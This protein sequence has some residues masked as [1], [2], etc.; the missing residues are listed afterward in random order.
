M[1]GQ[2]SNW[3]KLEKSISENDFYAIA[4]LKVETTMSPKSLIKAYW[5][6][7]MLLKHESLKDSLSY[8]R[9]TKIRNISQLYPLDGNKHQSSPKDPLWQSKFKLKQIAKNSVDVAV[10]QGVM[11]TR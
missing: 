7:H 8:I 11:T 4:D 5:F 6:L 3:R 10:L 9:L 2:V 1:C